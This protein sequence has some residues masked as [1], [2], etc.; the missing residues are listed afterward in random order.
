MVSMR[1]PVRCLQRFYVRDLFGFMIE[2]TTRRIHV[3]MIRRE[4]ERERET[5][6]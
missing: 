2:D 6:V 1:V 3:I 4:V 5:D